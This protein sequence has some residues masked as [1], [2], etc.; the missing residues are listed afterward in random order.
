MTAKTVDLPSPLPV[1][2]PPTGLSRWVRLRLYLVGATLV[3]LF[4]LLMARAFRLQ[5]QMTDQ[6]RAM[7]EE[8]YLQDVE[9]PA[10]RGRILDRIGTELAASTE[11]DSVFVNPRVL[12][13]GS[14]SLSPELVRNLSTALHL[15]RREV[16]QRLRSDRYFSWLKRRVPPEE[17]RAVRELNLQGVGLLREPKRY[18][19]NRGLAGPVLGWAGVDAVGQEGV[20]LAYDRWLRGSRAAIPG[21]RDALGRK[22]LTSGLGDTGRDR[23]HDVFLTLDKFIQFKLEQALEEGVA[24]H[25]AKAGVAVALD[26]RNG[27]ILAMAAVPSVNPNEPS[28]ARERGVRNRP[29]TDPFEPGSTMKP[30]TI[31]AALEA[32][33]VRADQE[34]DC[35][36]GKWKIGTATIHDAEP[37]GTLTTTQVLARSSNICTAKITRRLGREGTNRFLRGMGFGALSGVDLPG[38]RAGQLR[39]VA[40]WGDV[41]FA[42]ISFGQG[43]TATPIQLT[44]AL[45]AFA[46]GGIL[47]R[48]HIV[49]RVMDQKDHAVLDVKPEGRRVASE[50]TARQLR[51]ML[52]A[53]MQKKGTGDKLD[54]PGYPVA[55][56]TGTAQKVD[57]ATR[58]YSPE[59]WASSFMGFAPFDDPRLVLF[60]MIDEPQGSHYGSAVAGPVFVKVMSAALPYLGVAPRPTAPASESERESGKPAGARPIQAVEAV[61]VEEPAPVDPRDLPPEA[62]AAAEDRL[63]DFRGLA[64]GEALQLAARAHLR[65]EVNGSGRTV[66]QEP[67]AGSP[68]RGAVCRLRLAPA[69]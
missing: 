4:L 24:Q 60:V 6:Y 14:D 50:E 54:I 8:Q 30:F 17:A 35:E 47:Y 21:L 51:L 56:K 1:A 45:A 33:V 7:A 28:G 3:V 38:E 67:P 42:T 23:G 48:P 61:E 32:G 13:R 59:R 9:M 31:G 64:L 68:R 58:R 62:R 52:R 40:Q 46:N 18:Y 63:P 29:V 37:E 12:R 69:P 19:P 34:W 39:P 53:V 22:L 15:E 44:T 20:E 26:P 57:P 49:R 41:A 27:E 43:M 55:G 11:V 16:A 5:V 65:L 25:H 10:H 66:A 2:E 36:G